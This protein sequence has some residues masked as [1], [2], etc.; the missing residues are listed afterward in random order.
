MLSQNPNPIH[1]SY[2]KSTISTISKTSYT[3]H[4]KQYKAKEKTITSL[5]CKS[6]EHKRSIPQTPHPCSSLGFLWESHHEEKERPKHTQENNTIKIIL[7]NKK[8]M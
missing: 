3:T 6:Q 1:N 4:Q 7:S 8:V 5:D 2:Q